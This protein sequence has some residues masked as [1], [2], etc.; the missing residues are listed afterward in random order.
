MFIFCSNRSRKGPEQK[1][2]V[3]MTNRK[4]HGKKLGLAIVKHLQ[5]ILK[6]TRCNQKLVKSQLKRKV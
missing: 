5:T 4:R 6:I 3:A 2:Q 1:C